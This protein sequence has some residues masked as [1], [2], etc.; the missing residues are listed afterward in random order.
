M[1]ITG[2]TFGG[3]GGFGL[4]A[5]TG[6]VIDLFGTGFSYTVNGITTFITS[7]D[8]PASQH[9]LLL[10]TLGLGSMVV[11]ARKKKAGAAG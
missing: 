5:N 3:Q 10:L 4:N 2:G 7:G 6:G 11:A 9:R 8:L 1:D